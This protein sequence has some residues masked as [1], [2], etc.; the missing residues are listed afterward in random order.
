[1]CEYD[2]LSAWCLVPVNAICECDIADV[3][4]RHKE[5]VVV[6]DNAQ[7]VALCLSKRLKTRVFGNMDSR[8]SCA[9]CESGVEFVRPCKGARMHSAQ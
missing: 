5:A 2:S 6:D 1:M 9:S 4:I 8:N 3:K 7:R